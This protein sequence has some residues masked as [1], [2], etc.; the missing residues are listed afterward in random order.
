[1]TEMMSRARGEDGE[2]DRES[3]CYK[4]VVEYIDDYMDKEAGRTILEEIE[5]MSAKMAEPSSKSRSFVKNAEN[6]WEEECFPAL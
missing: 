4:A 1:M 6:R 3:V 5:R 2:V